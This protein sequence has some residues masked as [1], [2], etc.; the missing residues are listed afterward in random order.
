MVGMMQ[1]VQV[2]LRQLPA[3]FD[4]MVGREPHPG[5]SLGRIAASA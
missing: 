1:K 5:I 2:W 4:E 3:I